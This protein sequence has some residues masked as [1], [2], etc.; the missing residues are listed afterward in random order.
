M[1]LAAGISSGSGQDPVT[2]GNSYQRVL[3]TQVWRDSVGATTPVTGGT[4]QW[5]SVLDKAG[6]SACSR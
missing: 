1:P 5:W 3:R 4:H 6:W 2:M